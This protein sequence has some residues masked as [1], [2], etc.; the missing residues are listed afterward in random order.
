MISLAIKN[1]KNSFKAYRN[2]YIL[3]IVS[4]IAT[5]LILLFVYGV[6]ANSSIKIKEKEIRIKNISIYF[7]ETVPATE[8]E[9]LLSEVIPG[10]ESQMER[11]FVDMN[12]PGF[13][14]E[15]MAAFYYD[16]GK[17]YFPEKGFPETRLAAGRYM[18]WR[19]MTD[20]NN[21]AIA[22]GKK[23][24]DYP[25]YSLG[26]KCIIAG[27][28]YEIVGILDDLKGISRVNIPLS[29]CTDDM[30][31]H[32]VVIEYIQFPTVNDYNYISFKLFE[33]FGSGVRM[34]DLELVEF[35]D[36]IS[37]RSIILL[38]LVIGSIAAFDTILV[39]NYLI[40]KRKK[41]LA[42]F[43][44]EGANRMNQILICAIEVGM[45]TVSSIFLGVFA[46][47][48]LIKKALLEAYEI[49]MSI[50]TIK[51]YLYLLLSYFCV[52][53]LGTSMMIIMSTRKKALDVRRML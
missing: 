27:Q 41:Q 23:E 50:Y 44:I 33:R 29:A 21:I 37:Y 19:E 38:A 11:C 2:I 4:Q 24:G 14:L 3:L 40:K 12:V 36:I 9:A 17:Y 32:T 43:S 42:I 13:E 51:I 26:D 46:F 15:L 28:E 18:T 34:S 5:V 31:V 30:Q 8:V 25:K 48:L 53:I 47:E 20:G 1:I 52:I 39:Y 45:I 49:T 10:F 6:V 22:Y 35:D 7:D 16:D